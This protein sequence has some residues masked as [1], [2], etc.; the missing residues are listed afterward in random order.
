M[1]YLAENFKELKAEA[2]K[3]EICEEWRDALEVSTNLGTLMA[4]LEVPE[5]YVAYCYVKEVLEA[6]FPL[7]E[8]VIA[9]GAWISYRYAYDI[10]EAPFPAGEPVMATDAGSSYFYATLVL[11]APFPAGEPAIENSEFAD[12]YEQFKKKYKKG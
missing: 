9:K 3:A 12:R 11:E 5:S 8:P 7:V 6:P 4:L 2:L 1:S 10:L